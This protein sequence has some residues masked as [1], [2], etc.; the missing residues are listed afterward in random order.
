MIPH[1]RNDHDYSVERIQQLSE[2][3]TSQQINTQIIVAYHNTSACI[4]SVYIDM[5]EL[6]YLWIS[7]ECLIVV[8]R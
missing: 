5:F 2:Q 6:M 8:H 4:Y 3:E 1:W 7:V